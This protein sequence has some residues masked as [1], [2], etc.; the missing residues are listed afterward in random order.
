MRT[1]F[2]RRNSG[3]WAALLGAAGLMF[4]PAPSWSGAAPPPPAENVPGADSATILRMLQDYCVTGHAR[5]AYAME[6]ARRDGFALAPTAMLRPM[7]QA[8]GIQ[9]AEVRAK[10]IDRA[11]I[12]VASG[13][14]AER[15]EAF[16]FCAVGVTPDPAGRLVEEVRTWVGV[17]P[18]ATEE[19]GT[20]AFPYVEMAD[21]R[22]RST[23]EVT[24][25]QLRRA[26]AEGRA[27]VVI[28]IRTPEMTMLMYG[29]MQA[30][31]L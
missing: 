31:T 3:R 11:M 1:E 8:A 25:A 22:R 9:N 6:A 19:N 29:T 15:G 21:G 26:A 27:H 14:M 17:D 20:T 28:V 4:A 30:R 5:S 23:D 16:D 18:V 2:L 7:V 10:F 12:M 24:A 13:N